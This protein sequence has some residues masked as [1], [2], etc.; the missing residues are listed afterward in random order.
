MRKEAV[1]SLTLSKLLEREG[2]SECDLIK[3]DIEGAEYD[4]LLGSEDVLRRGALRHIAV[5]I[6]DS[7]L[8]RRGITWRMLHDW[9]L[10]CGYRLHAEQ[11]PSIYSI[12]NATE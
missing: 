1:P 2:I 4:V 8:R 9:M 6:H 10:S 3:I 11:G 12:C 5:E 7:I